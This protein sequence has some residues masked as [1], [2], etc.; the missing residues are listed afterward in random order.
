MSASSSSERNPLFREFDRAHVRMN[1]YEQ[2]GDEFVNIDTRTQHA[3]KLEGTPGYEWKGSCLQWLRWIVTGGTCTQFTLAIMRQGQK[4]RY[5]FHEKGAKEFVTMAKIKLQGKLQLA[6][7]DQTG[8]KNM[9]KDDISGLFQFIITNTN[10][11][12][13]GSKKVAVPSTQAKYERKAQDVDADWTMRRASAHS[14]ASVQ[15]KPTGRTTS[16]RTELATRKLAQVLSATHETYG[17]AVDNGDCFYDAIAQCLTVV[18]KRS[19]YNPVTIK[20]L[21]EVVANEVEMLHTKDPT[22]NWIYKQLK[23][24]RDLGNPEYDELR[25]Q[26][27]KP[28]N[29]LGPRELP[30]WGRLNLEGQ[31]IS[32]H[33]KTQIQLC[34]ISV[35]DTTIPSS[36][37]HGLKED[38]D[39]MYFDAFVPVEQGLSVLLL[40]ACDPNWLEVNPATSAPHHTIKIALYPGHFVPIQPAKESSRQPSTIE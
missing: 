32:E 11:L 39:E 8:I 29:E 35:V 13:Q 40:K 16:R 7:P 20:E 4:V 34:E 28:V 9:R 21:R 25:R 17:H 5:V 15:P 22:D 1:L 2:I 10:E 19:R 27:R 14:A 23:N 37:F 26:V 24:S 31:I 36:K 30:I 33:Y 18:L 12:P 38:Y 3:P 6:L